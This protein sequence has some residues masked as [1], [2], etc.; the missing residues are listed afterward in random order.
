MGRPWSLMTAGVAIIGGGVSYMSAYVGYIAYSE[1]LPVVAIIVGV[2]LL[3]EGAVKQIS[4]APVEMESILTLGWGVLILAIGTVGDLNTRGYPL[5]IL[6]AAFVILLG[7]LA[8]LAAMRMWTRRT[9]QI[10]KIKQ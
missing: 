6:L 3:L 1:V 8:V 4:P 9:P 7:A 5:A 2:W 10:E